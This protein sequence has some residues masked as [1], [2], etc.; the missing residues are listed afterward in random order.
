MVRMANNIETLRGHAVKNFGC[1]WSKWRELKLSCT[2][3]CPQNEDIIIPIIIIIIIIIIVIA[4]IIVII[5]IIIIIIIAMCRQ[6]TDSASGASG[7]G[8][9]LATRCSKPCQ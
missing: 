4:I 2:S 9:Y 7:G 6:H 3:I 8:L 5:I 1:I